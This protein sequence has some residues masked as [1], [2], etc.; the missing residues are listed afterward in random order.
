MLT[1]SDTAFLHQEDTQAIQPAEPCGDY[2][3]LIDVAMQ[4]VD[5]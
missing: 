3:A 4:W 1:R 2:V 5:G